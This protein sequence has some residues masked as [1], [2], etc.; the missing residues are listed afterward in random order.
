MTNREFCDI[1]SKR[2][3]RAANKRSEW[4]SV[5]S[6]KIEQRRDKVQRTLKV[7]STGSVYVQG[8]TAQ[9]KSRQFLREQYK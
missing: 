5:W 6:L 4:A 2:S 8:Y 3:T 1:L 7:Q 9:P